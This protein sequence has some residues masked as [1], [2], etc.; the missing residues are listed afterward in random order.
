MPALLAGTE[1]GL[2][3][4]PLDTTEAD[5]APRVLALEGVEVDPLAT[6]AGDLHVVYAATGEDGFRRSRDGGRTWEQL[7]KPP[8]GSS[9]YTIVSHP[10]KSGTVYAGLEPAAVWQSEDGGITWQELPALQGVPDKD[11]WR[12]FPP[13]QAHV[14]AL[15]I[16]QGSPETIYVGIEE[17]GVYISEDGGQSF[18]SR[19]EGLYR[20]IHKVFP[21]PGS[22]QL[23]LA[24]T[25][26]G[27]YRSEDSGRHWAHITTG[28]TRSYTVPL[29]IEPTYPHTVYVAAA[30]AP[31]PS[32][33]RGE[34]RADAK[35]F[36]S[37]DQGVTWEEWTAGFPSP[38]KGMVF[39][40][41]PH[42][43][44]ATH[45]FAGTTDGRIFQRPARG[46]AWRS[47]AEGLPPVYSLVVQP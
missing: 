18:Q 21:Y 34:R 44:D 10:S 37:Q 8:G 9:L 42:P 43:T 19:N 41:G 11:L 25:G 7:W 38:Q 29:Y 3:L 16:V 5:R 17:G 24:T 12:F 39:C 20:D 6:D 14:R 4:V 30:S 45:L 27:L 23:L 47:V 32:W 26:D 46:E 22:S 36:R 40:L 35:I 28:I 2:Y 13:R 1:N 31:P 33:E 15:T